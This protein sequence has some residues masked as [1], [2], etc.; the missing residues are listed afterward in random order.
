MYLEPRTNANERQ[1]HALKTV[2]L[3]PGNERRR[4]YRR[5]SLAVTGCLHAPVAP[6]VF[7]GTALSPRLWH[8]RSDG[9]KSGPGV[10]AVRSRQAAVS[11]PGAGELAWGA[12][13]IG[14]S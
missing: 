6:C 3:A 5:A 11:H 10:S 8:H 7:A 2:V 4:S 1:M 9:L 12:C 14:H 13:N